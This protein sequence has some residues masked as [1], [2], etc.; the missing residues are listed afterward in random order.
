MSRLKTLLNKSEDMGSIA[1]TAS[2]A[3]VNIES[4]SILSAQVSVTNT[5]AA[6]GTFTAVAST[7][8][9]TKTAHGLV[10]GE[11]AQVSNSGGALPT[12]LSAATNY[13][14]IPIDADTFYLAS[15][16]VNAQ[17]G[18]HIDLTTN[19]TG[20]QT[21]TPTALSATVKLQKSNNAG[22]S[23]ADEGNATS[24]TAAGDYWLEKVD[25]S[26]L[27]YKVVVTMTAGALDPVIHW[28]GKGIDG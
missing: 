12:G 27:L 6:A 22:V 1:I 18:T 19:G 4:I 10:L 16:L 8:V 5:T 14:A 7:D 11:V 20:T 23:W 13:Y 17:A 2:S 15:S 28:G 3:S 24:I 21:I 25:P 26:G 9:M